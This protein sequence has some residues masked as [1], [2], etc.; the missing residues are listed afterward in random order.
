VPT[1]HLRAAVCPGMP[2]DD[3][4][5]FRGVVDA[6]GEDTRGIGQISAWIVTGLGKFGV[7][8]SDLPLDVSY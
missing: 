6:W 1:P 8:P 3:D 5:R 4:R 2:Y 7:A